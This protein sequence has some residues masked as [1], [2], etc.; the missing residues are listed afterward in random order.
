MRAFETWIDTSR[1]ATY[2]QKAS[3][4][5]YQVGQAGPAGPATAAAETDCNPGDY[6]QLFRALLRMTKKQGEEELQ[7]LSE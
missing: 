7:K 5:K 6:A 4:V 2:D 3:S 1:R